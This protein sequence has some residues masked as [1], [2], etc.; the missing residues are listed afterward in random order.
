MPVTMGGVASGIDTED[1]IKK[2]VDV[3]SRPII[4]LQNEKSKMQQKKKILQDYGTILSNLQKN[5]KDL[6]GARASYND[7]KGLSSNAAAL[8]VIASKH[9]EKGTSKVKVISI[10]STHKI[11]T[12]PVESGDDL[13]AGQFE[14]QVGDEKRTVKFRGGTIQKLKE[15][16]D[17][18]AGSFVTPSLVNTE[19]SKYVMSL[20]SK[21]Q[22]KNGEMKIRGDKEFLKKIGLVKGEKDEDREKVSIVFDNKYF[23]PYS[24]EEK[25]ENQDG[26]L[27]VS[28]D[29]KTIGVKGVLWREYTM[30]IDVP[31]KKDTILQIGM[32]YI[33]SAPEAREDD[34][35]PYKIE[36]G[37]DEVTVIKGIELHGYNVS[38]E[39]TVEKKKRKPSGDDIIGAGV[40]SIENGARKEK[41]YKIPKDAKGMREFPIGADFEGKKISKI[42]FYCNDGEA[43]FSDGA[44][45][46][47]FDKKGLLDPK[48]TIAEAKDAKLK[49]DGVDISRNKNDGISDVIKGV[50]LNLKGVTETEV[51]VT[52]DNDLDNAVKKILAFIEA[53]NKYL[54]ITGDLTHTAKSE[55]PGDYEKTKGDN[56][57][58]VGDMAIIRLSNQIK[59]LIGGAYPSKVENPLKVL[60]QVGISTG[61]I[62]SA[63]ETIKEGKLILDD[64]QLRA[65]ISTN[66]EGV[67]ELFGSDNDGDNRM[68]NGFAYMVDTAIEPYV[69]TGKNIIASKIDL[70]GDSIKRADEYIAKQE[71]HV[72]LY[73]EKLRRKFA[74]MEK[75]VSSSKTQQSWMKQQMNNTNNQ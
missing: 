75:A 55:K 42:I 47:P 73:A 40:V 60:A 48:N 54:E 1:I 53:Y 56:G 20:E 69:R 46:T 5:A 61:K 31:V 16:I 71:D 2:L 43:K 57:L 10:A 67:R 19:G 28:Q 66:P 17:E 50:T 3:E 26:T 49:V 65:M 36:V 14:I 18:I 74:S 64:Q 23:S 6:Y 21:T 68:D 13:P 30:P 58:F 27:T 51:T 15:K 41:I 29:G 39:R 72:K 34:S 22:G 7:K 44:I 59:L 4:K 9:A 52:I 12:D 24:G 37:P 25:T 62:N 11:T 38:R 35:L 63:W 45:T 33:S 32:E 8:E 70:E